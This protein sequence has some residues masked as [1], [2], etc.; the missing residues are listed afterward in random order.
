M[1][2]TSETQHSTNQSKYQMKYGFPI[3]SQKKPMTPIT[4]MP[5]KQPMAYDL[6]DQF[7]KAKILN[8][9]HDRDFDN[10][11]VISE[12]DENIMSTNENNETQSYQNP[13]NTSKNDDK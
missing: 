1:K 12:E 4:R 11:N 10:D 9:D 6:R 5:L 2:E 7:I 8:T 13:V 3:G